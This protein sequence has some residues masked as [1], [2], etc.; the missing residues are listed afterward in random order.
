M[1][2]GSAISNTM[3]CSPPPSSYSPVSKQLCGSMWYFYK[4]NAAVACKTL[5]L[6]SSGLAFA[7]GNT[8]TL[9]PS[10]PIWMVGRLRQSMAG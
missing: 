8:S 1:A 10:V 3:P 5:G 2:V 4:S 7:T 6:G 9:L